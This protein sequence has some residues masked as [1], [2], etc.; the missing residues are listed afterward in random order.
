MIEEGRTIGLG[1]AY[2]DGKI[3]APDVH[4][5]SE[6]S[7]LPRF[8][9][10]HS[11]AVL[12]AGGAIPNT[13]TAFIRL[14]NQPNITLLS[15]IGNDPRGKLYRDH[16]DVRLGEPQVSFKNPTGLW[17]GIYNNGEIIEYGDF[18]G[19]SV[20]LS[21]SREALQTSRNMM[22]ITDVDACS[23]PQ[24][25]NQIEKTFETIDNNGLFALSL[26]GA[27][28]RPNADQA[29]SFT[30]FDPNMVFGTDSELLRI[31]PQSSLD[32]ALRNGFSQSRL[33]VV[34]QR[35]KGSIIRFE[36]QIF[37]IPRVHISDEAIIDEGGAG[38]SYMGTMLALLSSIKY[39]NWK[40]EDVV[41]AAH[42][43][44]YASSLVIQSSQP[45]LTPAMARRVLA[46]QNAFSPSTIAHQ[47]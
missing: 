8:L 26:S 32:D 24:M 41:R 44:S 23:T 20:D 9:D 16:L 11:E 27:N 10:A 36:G 40:N 25:R 38:D 29:L 15:C 47:L 12:S 6:R 19:A 17:V 21:V 33:L 46:Y 3:Y 43:A 34:T 2:V 42:A 1:L 7:E 30:A 31:T 14:A 35:E 5:P 28:N 37:P 18:F 22:L 45:R 4:L 13:V 39:A